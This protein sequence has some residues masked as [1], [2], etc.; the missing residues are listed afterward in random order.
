MNETMISH[1][2]LSCGLRGAGPCA[3]M[4]GFRPGAS[5]GLS[6]SAIDT[7]RSPNPQLTSLCL[8]WQC[9]GDRHQEY[10]PAMGTERHCRASAI[11]SWEPDT[12]P[13]LGIQMTLQWLDYGS[14][15][16]MATLAVT[17]PRMTQ[18]ML[19]FT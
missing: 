12:L 3:W 8:R 2:P 18:K 5:R 15:R 14:A 7:S 10:S 4:H 16:T 9:Q 19:P 1:L 13:Y 17:Q 6:A 11:A